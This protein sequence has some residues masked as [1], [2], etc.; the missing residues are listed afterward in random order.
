MNPS[1]C[2]KGLITMNSILNDYTDFVSYISSLTYNEHVDLLWHLDN[3]FKLV[4]PFL[5]I[6]LLNSIFTF[7]CE[8]KRFR[9]YFGEKQST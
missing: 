5:L 6:S 8:K 9:N 3:Y 1:E 7:I 4:L 2:G